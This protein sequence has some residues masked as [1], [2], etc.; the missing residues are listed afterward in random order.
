VGHY[1]PAD[2]AKETRFLTPG[3]EEARNRVS[4]WAITHQL[5]GQ[6]K[7]DFSP[8][9][10]GWALHLYLAHVKSNLK[11]SLNRS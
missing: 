1:T 11:T 2:W 4:W 5:T 10:S 9:V 3:A 6:K 7:P 8:L